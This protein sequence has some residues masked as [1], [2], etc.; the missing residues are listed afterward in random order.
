M[1]FPYTQCVLSFMTSL[2]SRRQRQ[3]RVNIPGSSGKL[4]CGD[5]V[6]PEGEQVIK[7]INISKP[8]ICCQPGFRRFIFFYGAQQISVLSTFCEREQDSS[9]ILSA[10]SPGQQNSEVSMDIC[11][12]LEKRS[13]GPS[14]AA[15]ATGPHS[16]TDWWLLELSCTSP[17]VGCS[18]GRVVGDGLAD[19]SSR[20]GEMG[21]QR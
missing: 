9:R 19:E 2:F 10:S 21:E 16:A 13:G 20:R 6:Q 3:A 8:M 17:W 15:T 12:D 7:E 4:S 1:F 5:V 11:S 14:T 18:R